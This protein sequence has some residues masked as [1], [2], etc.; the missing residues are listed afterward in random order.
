WQNQYNNNRTDGR[1]HM[2]PSTGRGVYVAN[3]QSL[4]P[5][6]PRPK[7]PSFDT[8]LK[9][10]RGDRAAQAQF[11][12][13]EKSQRVQ[14]QQAAQEQGLRDNALFGGSEGAVHRAAKRL[15]PVGEATINALS[16]VQAALDAAHQIQRH[17]YAAAGLSAAGILP[18]GKAPK[19]AKLAEGVAK[20]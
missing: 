20:G 12:I 9:A 3:P 13:Y 6:S 4:E 11:S 8:A 19:V 15:N 10:A 18:F 2:R 5:A 17:R 14:K 16:P 7:R 1:G